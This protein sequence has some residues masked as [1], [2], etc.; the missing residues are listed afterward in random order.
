MKPRISFIVGNFPALSSTFI[1][2][3][4]TGLIDRGFDVSI[5]AK[6]DPGESRVH[7][8]F[9]KYQLNEKVEY[10]SIPEGKLKRIKEA[11][12]IIVKNIKYHPKMILK[13]FNPFFFPSETLRLNTIFYLAPF[14][15]SGHDIIFSHFG[16]NGLIGTIL[17]RLGIKGK[18]VTVFHG[19]DISKFLSDHNNNIYHP[20]FKEGDLFLPVSEKWAEKLVDIGCPVKKI[21]VMHMGI[22]TNRFKKIPEKREATELINLLTIGRLVEKKG[23]ETIIKALSLISDK[24]KWKYTIAGDGPLRKHL[25]Q[26]T[27]LFNLDNNIEFA[28]PVDEMEVLN[29][30]KK[31]D[32]FILP[33]IT[34]I[35]GDSEGIPMVLMEAMAMGLP[36]ISTF[37]S[38]IPELVEDGV[39]GFLVKEKDF[40][41][42]S[43]K[44]LQLSKNSALR[45][46]MGT[47]G[48]KKIISEFN[49]TI[50]NDRLSEIF[51][52][53]LSI[54]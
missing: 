13:C 1:L 3:Q 42:I 4:I 49:L 10:F 46:S 24:F 9:I 39:S 25:E 35:D 47:S 7:S 37:H 48:R 34:G 53:L 6:K 40:S 41:S 54:D 15:E 14:L 17:R 43:S 45:I 36:V 12:R 22:D 30:Y 27:E 29:L 11:L 26:L 51:F 44:I 33:S 2:N 32:I 50:Q 20:L 23:H 8:N 18:L 5:F 16:P 19:Y 52:N 28:G 38:G 31:S 21:N